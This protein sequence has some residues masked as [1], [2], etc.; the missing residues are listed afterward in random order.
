[1]L[2]KSF[3]IFNVFIVLFK[4]KNRKKRIFLTKN[5]TKTN[6]NFDLII[7]NVEI[8]NKLNLKFRNSKK[9][10]FEKVKITIASDY[11]YRLNS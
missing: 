8:A 4:Y 1:M 7:I 11:N 2:D 3:A 5:Q 9:L 6:Q 10:D